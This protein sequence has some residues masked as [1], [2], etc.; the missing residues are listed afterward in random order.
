LD[1]SDGG[2]G[3]L[4]VPDCEGR[5]KLFYGAY[6][7]GLAVMAATGAFDSSAI[8]YRRSAERQENR[9]APNDA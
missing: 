7:D 4:I 1:Q 6:Q 5:A 2:H 8:E 3:E 9:L